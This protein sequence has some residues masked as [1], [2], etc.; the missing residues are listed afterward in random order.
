MAGH[1]RTNVFKGQLLANADERFRQRDLESPK[2]Y[3][4]RLEQILQWFKRGDAHVD[5]AKTRTTVGLDEVVAQS[6][7]QETHVRDDFFGHDS[8]VCFFPGL[9]GNTAD[10]I[11]RGTYIRAIELALCSDPA[12]PIVSYWITNGRSDTDS[13]AFETFVAESEREIHVL[14][15]TPKPATAPAG[16]PSRAIRERMF[17]V[18]TAAR[19][20]EIR[21]QYPAE[22]RTRIP[23]PGTSGVDCLQVIGY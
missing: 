19:V 13:D 16:D 5:I 4:E 2:D 23:L 20:G 17:F 11:V 8:K 1:E 15:L 7:E 14:L 6:L 18:S 21:A 10:Q 12:K 9:A 3:Q 22:L